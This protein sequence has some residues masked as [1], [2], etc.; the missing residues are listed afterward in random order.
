MDVCGHGGSVVF[1]LG[2]GKIS[3][4]LRMNILR[5]RLNLE[6]LLILALTKIRP[7]TEVLACQKQAHHLIKRSEPQ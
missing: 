3:Q 1:N 6:P 2:Y 5:N 4:G 7:R